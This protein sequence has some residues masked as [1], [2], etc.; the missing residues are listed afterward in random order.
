MTS[1]IPP[2][3]VNKKWNSIIPTL[4]RNQIL[5]VFLWETANFDQLWSKNMLKK[6]YRSKA[7]RAADWN[8]IVKLR[9]EHDIS[10]QSALV[11][12]DKD[13]LNYFEIKKETLELII[14]K[15]F[16]KTEL[17][18]LVWILN[19]YC[20]KKKRE[21]LIDIPTALKEI[22]CNYEN[23][24]LNR[25]NFIS[26]LDKFIL[27][28]YPDPRDQLVK[29]YEVKGKY[30]ELYLTPKSSKRNFYNKYNGKKPRK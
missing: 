21:W 30:L 25:K 20:N 4:S 3:K 15:G 19:L 16:T 9:G 17:L 8:S 11:H 7:K 22:F 23:P 28:K 10:L 27:L 13:D 6:I 14:D 24:R 18:V 29:S 12:Y 1:F 2:V 26:A 5:I